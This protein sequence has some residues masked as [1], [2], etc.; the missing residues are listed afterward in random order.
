MIEQLVPLLGLAPVL[1]A[2]DDPPTQP[3]SKLV[4][5]L[6]HIRKANIPTTI[7]SVCCISFLLGSRIVKRRLVKRPGGAW[8]R[9]IPEIL[10]CVVTVTGKL[11][12]AC[13]RGLAH[14]TVLT[15]VFRWDLLGVDIL[16]KLKGGKEF[17]FGLPLFPRS[18]K[19]VNETVGNASAI[20]VD[21]PV[22]DRLRHGCRRCRRLDGR[23][24]GELDQVRLPREPKPRACCPG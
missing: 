19:Y 17:P 23:G 16:G 12:T 21:L 13:D 1:R 8:L 20:S 7:L 15:Q 3:L 18:L 9:Y 14:V 5:I 22:L 24:Q 2:H 4:F 6:K 10:I 11:P